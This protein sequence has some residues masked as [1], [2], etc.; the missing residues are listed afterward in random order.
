VIA[1]AALQ[2]WELRGPR[3]PEATALLQ[4]DKAWRVVPFGN[5]VHVSAPR[6]TDLPAWLAAQAPA[7]PWQTS[8]IATGLEDV[9]IALTEDAQDNFA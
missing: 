9:F 6:G 1:H 2:T 4:Q 5:A 3:L 7:G 8:P